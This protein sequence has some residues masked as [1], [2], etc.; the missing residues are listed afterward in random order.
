MLIQSSLHRLFICIV[1]SVLYL[2]LLF[3]G[4]AGKINLGNPYSVIFIVQLFATTN[5]SKIIKL[6]F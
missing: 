6:T 5:H 2:A 1:F 4:G 3:G